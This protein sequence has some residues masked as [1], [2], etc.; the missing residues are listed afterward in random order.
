VIADAMTITATPSLRR[1]AEIA[2]P[3]SGRPIFGVIF[4][5]L[6]YRAVSVSLP[7]NFRVQRT[8]RLERRRLTMQIQAGLNFTRRKM[9]CATKGQH[10]YSI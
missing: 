1:L 7:I 5:P 6:A 3:I 4:C 8:L 2:R 10:A 9:N